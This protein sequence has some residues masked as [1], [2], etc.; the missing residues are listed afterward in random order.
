MDRMRDWR[1]Q[2]RKEGKPTTLL[3]D[4]DCCITQEMRNGVIEALQTVRRTAWLEFLAG[5]N[6]KSRV[7]RESSDGEEEDS[8]DE[9]DGSAYDSEDGSR[10][11]SYA[12]ATVPIQ[13]EP[14]RAEKGASV[15]NE[16]VDIEQME[17]EKED[18][19]IG[20]LPSMEMTR[21][22]NVGARLSMPFHGLLGNTV[23]EPYAKA[24]RYDASFLPQDAGK[25]VW[26]KRLHSGQVGLDAF[27]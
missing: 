14:G 9:E 22:P 19:N 5:W 2:Q 18:A 25:F 8:E 11:V 7:E 6:K 13:K 3:A 27:C 21:D 26:G 24:I 1:T 4:D 23:W 12:G 15:K 20:P 16:V 17:R 10:K